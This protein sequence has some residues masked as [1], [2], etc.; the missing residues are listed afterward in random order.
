VTPLRNIAL[1]VVVALP[2]GVLISQIVPQRREDPAKVRRECISF[3]DAF[4]ANSTIS[5]HEL[6]Q[7]LVGLGV[8]LPT[9]PSLTFPP[10]YSG[11]EAE[12]LLREYASARNAY[13]AKS[14][15]VQ[16]ST[17]YQRAREAILNR[18]RDKLWRA[19]LSLF[20]GVRE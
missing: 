16:A 7:E 10:R 14:E 20:G 15:E 13:E 3:V 19:C 18:N 17:E 2:I 8:T 11:R 4:T 5:P 12:A 6:E 9:P 1:A